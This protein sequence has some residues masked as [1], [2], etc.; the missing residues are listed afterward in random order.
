MTTIRTIDYARAVEALKALAEQKRL[1]ILA[2][3]SAGERCAC[4]L[5]GC[6]ESSQPLLSFHLRTLREAGLVESRRDG[7]WIHYRVDRE[8]LRTLADAL[9][10]IADGDVE[11]PMPGCCE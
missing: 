2:T 7:R 6:C 3:L 8:A 9:V 5:T 10:A 1:R 4:E 11:E